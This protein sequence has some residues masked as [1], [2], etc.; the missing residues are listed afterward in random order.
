MPEAHD[1]VEVAA[2][3]PAPAPLSTTARTPASAS[4]ASIARCSSRSIA[5]FMAL[6]RSGRFK[7]TS[8]T[9]P[10]VS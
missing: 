10:R 4:A 9:A 5:P 2:Q 1:R 3:K 8:A 6:S 7:V